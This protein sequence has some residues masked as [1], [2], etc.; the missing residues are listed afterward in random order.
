MRQDNP[1]VWGGKT[2]SAII[3]LVITVVGTRHRHADA[4]V[5]IAASVIMKSL[6]IT[7]QN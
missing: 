3:A 1:W 5:I 2:S 6:L 7:Y 4:T